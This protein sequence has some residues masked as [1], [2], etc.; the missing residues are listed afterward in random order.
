MFPFNFKLSQI[1]PTLVIFSMTL[2]RANESP[3]SSA[4]SGDLIYTTPPSHNP[5]YIIKIDGIKTYHYLI[6]L[7]KTS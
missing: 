5:Q 7:T 2:L 4:I 3:K 6:F 1:N